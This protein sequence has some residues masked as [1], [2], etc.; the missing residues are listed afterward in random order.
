MYVRIVDSG[1]CFSTT[2][3]F[4]NGVYANKSEW[5]KYNF[6]PQNNMVGE[7]VKRTPSAYIVKI[8][9]GIYVPMTAKG[10]REISFADYQTGQK[11]NVCT[12]MNDRQQRI[13]AGV[14]AVVG[15]SWQH[16]P[17]MREAFKADIIEN[18][19][20]LT[21]DFERSIYLP[22]LKESAVMYGADMCLEYRKKSGRELD[23]RTVQEISEQ[24]TDVYTSFFND[25][26]TLSVKNDCITRIV[27]LVGSP[28]I[29]RKI[30]DGYYKRV[31]D[32]YCSW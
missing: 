32:L 9:D 21:C 4:I 19:K 13:N 23:P 22:D 25:D 15:N 24:V 10:I 7:V 31:N 16:L 29:A 27:D 20:K 17:D 14:N 5:A 11:Y 2:M 28:D 6:Y 3:E 12:G 1:E 26:F 8:K 18:M 30:I